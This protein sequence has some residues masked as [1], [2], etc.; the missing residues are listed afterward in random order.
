MCSSDLVQAYDSVAA[1]DEASTRGALAER[2]DLLLSDHRLPDGDSSDVARRVHAVQP[3]VPVLVIT[4]DTAP[5]DLARLEA[6]GWPVLHKPFDSDALFEA[7]IAALR[8]PR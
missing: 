7:M 6:L 8:P 2:P 1:L 4:G 3:G 5:G